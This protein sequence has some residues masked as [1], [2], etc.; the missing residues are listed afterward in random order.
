MT[1]MYAWFFVLC[2]RAASLVLPRSL[3]LLLFSSPHIQTRPKF[4]GRRASQRQAPS[5]TPR[6]ASA[7]GTWYALPASR[8][9]PP[10]GVMTR[11]ATMRAGTTKARVRRITCT[12]HALSSRSCCPCVLAPCSSEDKWMSVALA[13]PL[14]CWRSSRGRS[15]T[16]LPLV[17]SCPHPQVTTLIAVF[18]VLTLLLLPPRCSSL[19]LSPPYGDPFRHRH[20]FTCSSTKKERQ[21]PPRSLRSI[22][23]GRGCA[24][25]GQMYWSKG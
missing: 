8:P 17:L 12:F 22:G 3:L 10:Q 25:G 19:Y 6:S 20:H 9:C 14:W 2:V 15:H 7:H 11:S 18:L 16:S 21:S 4:S 24:C 13:R 5:S 23:A 1:H